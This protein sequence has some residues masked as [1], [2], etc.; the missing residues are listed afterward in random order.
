MVIFRAAFSNTQWLQSGANSLLRWCLCFVYCFI[1]DFV[2]QY[3]LLFC[4]VYH[5]LDK[6]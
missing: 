2:A 5:C 6:H 3:C 1:V 4:E